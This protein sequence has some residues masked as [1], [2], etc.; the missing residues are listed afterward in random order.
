MATLKRSRWVFIFFWSRSTLHGWVTQTPADSPAERLTTGWAD[1]LIGHT[2]THM[3]RDTHVPNTQAK[4]VKS[5]FPRP[6]GAR[7]LKTPTAP[8]HA[9]SQTRLHVWAWR[10]FAGR[11]VH[12]WCTWTQRTRPHQPETD[13]SFSCLHVRSV[14]LCSPHSSPAFACLS[15]AYLLSVCLLSAVCACRHSYFLIRSF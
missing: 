8:S 7:A 10:H 6:S 15:L 9:H 11:R 13:V 1:W 12:K 2:Q 3:C 5:R 14:L 4:Q